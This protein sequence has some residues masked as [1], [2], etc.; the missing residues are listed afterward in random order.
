[1]PNVFLGLISFLFAF[2]FLSRSGLISLLLAYLAF[3]LTH[4]LLPCAS[5]PSGIHVH[6]PDSNT[7]GLDRCHGPDAGGCR[8][9]VGSSCSHLLH[10]LPSVCHPGEEEMMLHEM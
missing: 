5:L 6:V 1:M 8:S 2:V 4:L 7:G 9:Y 10:P 3:S